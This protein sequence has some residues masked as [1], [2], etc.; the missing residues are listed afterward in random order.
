MDDAMNDKQGHSTWRSGQANT[1][2]HG[3]TPPSSGGMIDATHTHFLECVTFEPRTDGNG[4]AYYNL[5]AVPK[6]DGSLLTIRLK[7]YDLATHRR[8][9]VAL[10]NHGIFYLRSQREHGEMLMQL[11][12]HPLRP[13]PCWIP[14]SANLEMLK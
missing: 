5:R 12:R 2:G 9:R 8:F 3:T 13:G 11:L 10:L 4:V 6:G 1:H 14:F 7:P